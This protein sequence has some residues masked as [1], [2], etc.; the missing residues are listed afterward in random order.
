LRWDAICTGFRRISTGPG[1][2]RAVMFL[3]EHWLLVFQR[4]AVWRDPGQYFPEKGTLGYYDTHFLQALLYIPLRLLGI[5]RFLAFQIEQL[6]LTAIGFS[7]FWILSRRV[8]RA[9]LPIAMIGSLLFTAASSLHAS[10]PQAQLFSLYFVPWLC[11]AI[12]R[13]FR[14]ASDRPRASFASG[15]LSGA[16][17]ALLLYTSF[18]IG[19]FCAIAAAVMLVATALIAPRPS[20]SLVRERGHVLLPVVLGF[21]A[22]FAAGIIPFAY[23]YLP[24]VASGRSQELSTALQSLGRITDVVNAGAGNLMWG[25]LLAMLPHYP[26]DRLLDPNRY[27]TITPLVLATVLSGAI[28][29]L[30]ARRMAPAHE[31]RM[32]LVLAMTVLVLLF[33][34]MSI[35][36]HTIWPLVWRWIPGG[37]AIRFAWRLQIVNAAIAAA[38]ATIILTWLFRRSA[39]T[40][41]LLGTLLVVEQISSDNW[42][43]LDRRAEVAMLA[44]IPSPPKEC[45]AFA[46]VDD[47]GIVRVP[48][49][50]ALM[51]AQQVHLPTMNGLEGALYR[52]A[53]IEVI[54]RE[55]L[56]AS[57]RGQ[58][59]RFGWPSGVCVFDLPS[60]AWDT[61][62]LAGPFPLVQTDTRLLVGRGGQTSVLAGGWSSPEEWGT[63]NDGKYAVVRFRVRR[64]GT[65]SITVCFDV[66]ALVYGNARRHET[67]VA[68]NQHELARWTF[69]NAAWRTEAITIP[70]HLFGRGGSIE[71]TFTNLATHSPKALGLNEDTRSLGLSLRS[72]SVMTGA[73]NCGAPS[74]DTLKHQRVSP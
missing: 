64:A 1:D 10:T 39:A 8:L 42:A 21:A 17:Y 55:A 19:W 52:D 13:G 15:L 53:R 54:D 65:P 29:G 58:L 46:M 14:T 73:A 71:I 48:N 40:A 16:G 72:M 60:R 43:K 37:K 27:R 9:P 31:R 56:L 33:L 36:D 20:L 61:E 7:G 5:E 32:L 63:W 49:A 67:V 23:T 57:A 59:E 45:R 44:T 28:A 25:R 74:F 50:F 3:L 12:I 11:L 35:G 30:M 22:G 4:R 62:S 6:I 2:G 26:A 24:I 69:E 51:V 47:A 41:L 66:A 38:A 18:Y 70:P 34:P 68:V